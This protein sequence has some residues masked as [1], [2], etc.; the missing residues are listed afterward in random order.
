VTG[1][2][3]ISH[4]YS[5]VTESIN[6]YDGTL[7][8][9]TYEILFKEPAHSQVIT[10]AEILNNGVNFASIVVRTAG[11]VT[12]TGM[13]FA[14]AQQVFLVSASNLGAY[15]IPNIVKIQNATLVSATNGAEVA[16][17]VYDYY[18]QRYRQ[19]VRLYAPSISIGHV[20]LI[21]SVNNSQIRGALEKM[22]I[23]L[24]GGFIVDAEAVGVVE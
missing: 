13:K 18:Q 24:S 12:L 3:I 20:A 7:A 4:N 10:G 19:K 1:V 8:A 23:N 14:D 17:R 11:D 15:V 21:D 9:G 6:L 5:A 2:E 22:N 16:S